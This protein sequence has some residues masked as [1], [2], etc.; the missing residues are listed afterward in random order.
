MTDQ[1]TSAND[2]KRRA[3][4]FLIVSVS[5][6]LCCSLLLFLLPR[7]G[8]ALFFGCMALTLGIPISVVAGRIG[9]DDGERPRWFFLV[10]IAACAMVFY[11]Y[12][13]VDD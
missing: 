3:P 2:T 10:T 1:T 6:P 12:T 11:A 9:L 7:G 4:V 13:F 8:G 5:I